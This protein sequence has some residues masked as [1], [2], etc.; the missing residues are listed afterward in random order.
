MQS[1]PSAS[2]RR[3]AVSADAGAAGDFI[4]PCGVLLKDALAPPLVT[5][6]PSLLSRSQSSA[7]SCS[8]FRQ[9]GPERISRGVLAAPSDPASPALRLQAANGALRTPVTVIAIGCTSSAVSPRRR[10]AHVTIFAA[11]DPVCAA[12]ARLDFLRDP[13]STGNTLPADPTLAFP[14]C[15]L[16]YS[17]A[18]P[19][20][21]RATHHRKR[22]RAVRRGHRGFD[23]IAFDAEITH[24]GPLRLLGPFVGHGI[25]LSRDCQLPA[26]PGTL[27]ATVGCSAAEETLVG[28]FSAPAPVR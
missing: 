1:C 4:G 27:V 17:T 24:P 22:R 8:V 5:S 16:V 15:S 13:R 14:C 25:A 23:P 6:R 21:R 11:G 12:C 19:D 9:E 26:G 2:A 20:A 10:D 3:T 7:L 18:I 28:S